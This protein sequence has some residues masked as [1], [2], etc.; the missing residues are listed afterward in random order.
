MKSQNE[1]LGEALRLFRI[2]HDMTV[3]EMAKQLEVTSGYVSSIET[4]RKVPNLDLISKYAKIFQTT[5][6]AIL[7]FSEDLKS[8]KLPKGIKSKLRVGI[9]K[10]MRA[11]ES[12]A[13]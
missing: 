13:D 3:G 12:A 4:G 10:F 9:I 5:P 8:G 11:V 6:S 1:S 2:F 7:F